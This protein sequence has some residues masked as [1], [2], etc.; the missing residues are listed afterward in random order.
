M[1][2]RLERAP[3]PLRADIVGADRQAF[4]RLGARYLRFR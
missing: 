2:S 4:E 1:G 3:A